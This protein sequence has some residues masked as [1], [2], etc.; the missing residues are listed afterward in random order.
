MATIQDSGYGSNRT[1]VFRRLQELYTSGFISDHEYQ[2]TAS[3]IANTSQPEGLLYSPKGQNPS[4]VIPRILLY[5]RDNDVNRDVNWNVNFP[6]IQA[7]VAEASRDM[8]TGTIGY[9]DPQVRSAVEDAH[10]LVGVHLNSE[11][12]DRE[13][14]PWTTDIL[15]GRT[16]QERLLTYPKAFPPP[17]PNRG[18]SQYRPVNPA[19]RLYDTDPIWNTTLKIL[20]TPELAKLAEVDNYVESENR[21]FE[22][23]QNSA[24]TGRKGDPI[25][26]SSRFAAENKIYENYISGGLAEIRANVPPPHTNRPISPRGPDNPD[27]TKGPSFYTRRGW[28]RAALQQCLNLF[29]SH[30]NRVINTPWRRVVLPYEAPAPLPKVNAYI[31]RLPDPRGTGGKEPDPFSWIYWSSQYTQIVD[32]L[33]DCQRRGYENKSWD[34]FSA[35]ALPVNFRGPRI[36]RGLAVHDNHWLKIGQE[37]ENLESQLYAAWGAAPRPLLR[38]I[39]RDIDSGK[40]RNTGGHHMD[41]SKYLP[42]EDDDD[43]IDRKRY[44]RRDIKRRAGFDRREENTEDDN[45]ALIDEYEIAWLR[46]LCEPSRTLE[47]CDPSKLPAN[48]LAIVFDAKLQSFFRHVELSGTP[49]TK[50]LHIWEENRQD[51]DQVMHSY[52][53]S[54]VSEALAY[55]N[56]CAESELKYSGDTDYNPEHPNACYQ[57]SG[58]EA[59][60]LCVELQLLGRCVFYPARDGAPARVDRPAYNVHPEDR[61]IWRYMDLDHF[62]EDNAKYL[63]NMLQ[64][65]D[66]SYGNWSMYPENRPRFSREL[67]FMLDHAGADFA[68][69]LERVEVTQQDP[70]SAE[71]LMKRREFIHWYLVPEGLCHIGDTLEEGLETEH[72][73]PYRDDLA[74]WE[75]VGS[76]LTKYR[77]RAKEQHDAKDRFYSGEPYH[78]QTPER[79]AQ[80]LR[81]LAYRMGRTLRHVDK[82]RDRLQYLE[83][84]T[85]TPKAPLDLSTELKQP[86]PEDNICLSSASLPPVAQKWWQAISTRDYDLAIQKWN[87][88]IREGSGEIGLLPP[89]ISIVVA[90]ADPDSSFQNPLKGEQDPFTVIREGIIH[91]CFRNQPA[92]YPNRLSGFKD[93]QD[94]EFQGY[95]RSS[96]FAWATKEQR[97]YQAQHTRRHFFNMQ[98]WPLSR[99]LPHRLDA[100]RE[101]KDEVLKR[102]PSKPDQAYGILTDRLPRGDDKPLYAH[103]IIE[104]HNPDRGIDEWPFGDHYPPVPQ[105]FDD[106]GLDDIDTNIL[107]F[108]TNIL[109]INLA[110]IDHS[111]TYK[112]ILNGGGTGNM[113]HNGTHDDGTSVK[114]EIS[115]STSHREFMPF[116][117]SDE[118]FA[119]G[120]AVFPMGD[121]LLQKILISHELNNAL[122]PVRPFYKDPFTSV[123]KLLRG[124]IEAKPPLVPLVPQ[125]AKAYIP[126]SNPRKRNMPIEFL[127]VVKDSA[128]KKFRSDN[129]VPLQPGGAGGQFGAATIVEVKTPNMVEAAARQA[130]TPTTPVRNGNMP[131]K[132]GTPSA[133]PGIVTPPKTPN[134][135]WDDLFPIESKD[136]LKENPLRVKP[137]PPRN[138]ALTKFHS[139]FSKG[140]R[141]SVTE[142][143]YMLNA[144]VIALNF[145]INAQLVKKHGAKVR[146]TQKGLHDLLKSPDLKV[147]EPYT[148]LRYHNFDIHCLARLAQ[149][150]GAKHDLKVQL[151][152]AGKYVSNYGDN[153]GQT[154]YASWLVG[155]VHQDDP[156]KVIVW[157]WIDMIEHFPGRL[158][159]DYSGFD[160]NTYK[161]IAPSSG[162]E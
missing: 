139:Q 140:Y 27:G 120:P 160:Y 77:Q 73:S 8:E 45:F 146:S 59:E 65:Y 137:D 74:T 13:I 55:I 10:V 49:D 156:N 100:I 115:D 126:R 85:G 60:F 147:L 84:G 21:F 66:N 99:M 26:Q 94:N 44:W 106:G 17:E 86:R 158:I 113:D 105:D 52:E 63:A 53:P 23:T 152:L 7:Y 116:T 79:T 29:T 129:T 9:S 4:I 153:K 69:E 14:T 107:D 43:I 82:I 127:N 83:I 28:Q 64:H 50:T 38:A 91:D 35:P 48:N 42:A 104:H 157:V 51:F 98:R 3:N 110:E 1:H 67:E 71:A 12:R 80:F 31:P 162:D 47:M 150:Y 56:G 128:P 41:N 148:D 119:P 24:R 145:S 62:S 123:S 2:A 87:T 15:R 22:A 149:A 159:N 132:P 108:N 117:R 114:S 138:E 136:A 11:K 144:A 37:L 16:I 20:G 61:I 54:T 125:V 141:L 122:Y 154:I 46:H 112:Q 6:L 72:D 103:P 143:R 39:L 101:R 81:N 30:E 57:F 88:A 92:L 96:L 58:E 151:G 131:E 78:P 34:D 135:A 124:F 130:A 134:T 32:F 102:D 70:K 40:R 5:L 95:Q 89:D 33:A 111:E 68:P 18:K 121:T 109:D 133:V 19:P 97:R 36:Y 25:W 118:K 93:Q 142:V 161:G 90:K 76:Y 155:S 75:V